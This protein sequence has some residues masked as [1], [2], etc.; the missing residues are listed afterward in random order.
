MELELD[1]TG[2]VGGGKWAQ[3]DNI[4]E[5]WDRIAGSRVLK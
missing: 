4:L 2:P 5:V 1:P 3:S